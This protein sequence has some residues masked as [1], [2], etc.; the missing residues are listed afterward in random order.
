MGFSVTR[1]AAIAYGRGGSPR[2][3]SSTRVGPYHG[4]GRRRCFAKQIEHAGRVGTTQRSVAVVEEGHLVP[5]LLATW[6]LP[7]LL[8]V[9]L[10]RPRPLLR[11]MVQA[12]VVIAARPFT[13]H[14]VLGEY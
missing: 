1:D 2:S 3:P 4:A 10:E 5:L 11:R 8:R 14:A 6:L 7:V 9:N 12:C 13:T